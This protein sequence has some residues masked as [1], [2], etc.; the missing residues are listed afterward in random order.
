MKDSCETKLIHPEKIKKAK[1]VLEEE[2][3]LYDAADFFKIFGD[4]TRLKILCALQA[5]ELCVCD[6]STIT[7]TSQSAMSH[8]LRVLRN[9][10]VVKARKVGKEVFY[11]LDDEHISSI[12]HQGLEHIKEK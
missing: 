1:V 12:L 8:Q 9:I 4:S 7:K 2:E 3:T 11:S 5:G 6:L 10:K